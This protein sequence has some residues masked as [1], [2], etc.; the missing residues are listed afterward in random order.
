MGALL[1]REHREVLQQFAW[2]KVLLAFDYDGTLAPIVSDPRRAVLRKSTRE[3]LSQVAERYPTVVISGRSHA[4]VRKRVS[5]LGVAGV[6]GNH[7]LEPWA[8]A[9]RY[10]RAVKRWMPKLHRALGDV[11]GVQVENKHYSVALHYRHAKNKRTAR[12]AILDAVATLGPARVMGGKQVVNVLPIG[13]PHK[14]AALE[15]ERDRLGCDT[16]IYVGDDE[17]DEDVFTLHQPKRLLSVR[18]GQSARSL[19]LHHLGTQRDIDRLL[20]AL[21]KYRA[22]ADAQ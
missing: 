18:V 7:G 15:R 9:D 10:H 6:I 11:P 13:A 16:A 14:G 19:A 22:S 8:A 20:K 1:N 12:E 3:L 5:G 21:I 17:T 4:D 2:S